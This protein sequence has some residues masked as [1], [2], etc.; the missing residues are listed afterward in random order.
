MDLKVSKETRSE[1]EQNGSNQTNSH[2]AFSSKRR[3]EER[4]RKRVMLYARAMG[5]AKSD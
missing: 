2:R 4:L 5:E 1:V 3:K